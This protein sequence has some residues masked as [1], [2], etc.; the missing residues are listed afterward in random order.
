MNPLG[1]T[2]HPYAQQ[3]AP[4]LK[5]QNAFPHG[6]VP[7]PTP[8]LMPYYSS[9]PPHMDQ[10]SLESAYTQ[11]GY[12][13][14]TLPPTQQ[15]T[16]E[17]YIPN[18]M[19]NDDYLFNIQNNPYLSYQV[20]YNSPY[21]EESNENNEFLNA[22]YGPGPSIS[23]STDRICG[24]KGCNLFVFHLPNDMTNWLVL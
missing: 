15:Q 7:L 11:P 17:Y 22:C 18:A 24:P 23:T 4:L 19:H 14:Y 2:S 1:N 3:N 6:M 16:H 5:H 12:V 21:I 9:L 13:Q 8:V 20:P 10:L